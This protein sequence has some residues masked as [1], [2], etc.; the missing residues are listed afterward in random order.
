MGDEERESFIA[1]PII[2]MALADKSELFLNFKI[3]KNRICEKF[4]FTAWQNF[5]SGLILN[6][7]DQ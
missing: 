6:V 3:C 4:N 1:L 7:I 5:I 2:R